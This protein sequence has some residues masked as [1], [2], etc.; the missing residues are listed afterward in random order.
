MNGQALEVPGRF[1]V[2]Q[3]RGRLYLSRAMSAREPIPSAAVETRTSGEDPIVATGCR[4]GRLWTGALLAMVRE[5]PNVMP[6]F[7]QR[8]FV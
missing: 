2:T 4:G 5:R 7:G 3:G 8:K 1:F 6:R